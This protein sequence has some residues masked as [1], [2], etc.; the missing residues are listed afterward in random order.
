MKK[1]NRL[2]I[3]IC[4]LLLLC[5]FAAAC[6]VND[7]DD[8]DP[9]N[10]IV[11]EYLNQNNIIKW[12]ANWA[13][14]FTLIV[15]YGENTN[16]TVIY[17]EIDINAADN[18]RKLG[19]YFAQSG[20]YFAVLLAYKGDEIK[21]ET[22]VIDVHVDYVELDPN[23]EYIDPS[24][25]SEPEGFKKDIGKLKSV[26][27]HIAKSDEGLS[28]VLANQNGVKSVSG[29]TLSAYGDWSYDKDTNSLEIAGVY[30]NK[31]SLGARLSFDVEYND[32]RS[33]KINVQLVDEMPMEIIKGGLINSPIY[34]NNSNGVI[35]LLNLAINYDIYLGYGGKVASEGS[36][37]YVKDV[38][39]D[40]K[41]L[42]SSY[43]CYSKESKITLTANKSLS[44]LSYGMHLL[45][46]FTTH[47][48]S[49]VWLNVKGTNTYP[50]N[51][52]IDYDSSYPDIFVRWTMLR[53]DAEEFIVKI[54]DKEYSNKKYPELFD[55]YKFDA[56][57]KIAYG[58]EVRVT[59]VIGGKA[60]TSLGAT[61]DIDISN[62]AVQGY[63]SYDNSFEYLGTR[64][65]TFI[66]DYDELKD[67]VFYSL[68]HYDELTE[69]KES[70][71]EKMW[72]IYVNPSLESNAKGLQ[73]RIN[74]AVGYFNEG[75]KDKWQVNGGYINIYEVYF[76]I[77]STCVPDDAIRSSSV[78]ENVYNDV[79]F[80]KTGRSADFDGFAA[81]NLQKTA[82]VTYS[83]ELYLALERG[84]R[85][86]PKKGSS[87]ET[88][89]ERAK[90]ILRSIVDDNMDDYQKVHAIADWL[91]ANVSY[92]WTLAE[93]LGK[94]SPS[95]DSYNK[96][97]AYRELYLEGAILDGLAVCNGY[98][99]AVSLLCGIEGI[100]CYKIKGASGS[101][102]GIWPNR[103][104]P[105]HAWN[106]AYIDGSWYV[107]D[108]TWA[109]EKYQ[110]NN[111][112]VTKEVLKHNTLFMTE[113]QSGNR[114]DGAH[115]ETYVGDYSGYF[116]GSSYDV[117]ANTFFW[118]DGNIYDMVIDSESELEILLNYFESSKGRDMARGTYVTVDVRCDNTLLKEYIA[119]LRGK[120]LD[121]FSD[122]LVETKYA[123]AYGG[124]TSLVFSK[125]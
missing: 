73:Q 92:N 103:V 94:A 40:G 82:E 50:L 3:M 46:I 65:N 122:Y 80:S 25:P 29:F 115:Y 78:S 104:Y 54:G 42:S 62:P 23:D 26:Y 48:K 2:V 70:G 20:K 8:S 22:I 88:V 61:L 59:A 107:I 18:H 7:Y 85:P 105:Q 43:I 90:T 116:A 6:S 60:E 79:H 113:D 57:G 10:T 15:Y 111:S 118:Y 9:Q 16:G 96:Y 84:V 114:P 13:E 36:A 125:M 41:K 28:I 119:K 53:D 123:P 33:D 120:G 24:L 64:Y 27:Y 89:Y 38:S 31:F 34:S 108:S 112:S 63:L 55:G 102:S 44:G 19:G 39:I 74:S 95:S 83:E 21:R 66:K 12:T 97:Y 75:V 47:G 11:L 101:G 1:N 72:R 51:V 71:F 117:F 68:I 45:E 56:S 86:I 76:T 14:K 69:S 67:L 100:R 98:A 32:G 91:S 58:D 81:N 121:I 35:S 99:K 93:E 30:F 109:N 110:V 37:N 124:M 5:I 4:I 77:S 17:N 87:A 106:K 52:S 49:E